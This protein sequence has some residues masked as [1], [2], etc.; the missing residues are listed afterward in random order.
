MSSP[1]RTVNA[2][3][4][5]EAPQSR[6]PH[7]RLV[8]RPGNISYVVTAGLLGVGLVSLLMFDLPREAVGYLV[9]GLVLCALLLG[10]HIG[11]SM[12]L[13][14]TFGLFVLGKLPTVV[15]TFEGVVFNTV[16]SWQLS[17]IPMFVLMGIA[18]WKGGL[19]SRA[20]DVALLWLGRS[21]GGVAVGTNLAGAGL[22]AASGSSIAITVA[23]GRIAIPEMLKLKYSP[24]LA[25]GTVAMAGTL[26]QVIP[27]SVMLVIYS[28]LVQTAT[29]PQL[30]AGVVPGII[31]AVAFG[32]VIVV[33]TLIKPSSAPRVVT[34]APLGQKLRSLVGIVP[35]AVVVLVV[36]GGMLAGL[37]TPTEAGAF[38]ALASI[39]VS[40]L[41]FPRKERT[42][43]R[44][45]SFVG[46][47]LM[48]TVVSSAALFLLVI[49][50]TVMTRLM[51]LSGVAQSATN[52]LV[53]LGMP[54]VVFLLVLIVLFVL[55][56]MFLDE[57]SMILLTL[58]VL[59]GP[60][61]ALGVDMIWFGIFLMM[62]VQIGMVAPPI[63]ILSFI[64]HGLTK[65]PAVNQGT[66]SSSP[67]CS[68][69]WPRSSSSRS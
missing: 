47:S 57:L 54:T 34:R 43:R 6:L 63:G 30:I 46:E 48:E 17:V 38:G 67:T 64:V 49:G 32:G 59:I 26:G 18:M 51:A 21:P 37:Y 42:F 36:I 2:P 62:L 1:T 9:I 52:F 22:S 8:L 11:V 28:G 40:V 16:A 33:W 39:V 58:P 53:G 41:S 31:L 13:I 15:G 50:V 27:P 61:T 65:D 25:T 4:H 29:G 19:T 66:A 5:E 23:L 68:R 60:L 24:A 44:I 20:F 3:R 35:I 69:V 45:R 10:V 7:R 12:I 55:L 56:G 14:P